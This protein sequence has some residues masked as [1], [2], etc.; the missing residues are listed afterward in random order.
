M[1]SQQTLEFSCCQAQAKKMAP[2]VVV[3]QIAG[4]KRCWGQGKETGK[5]GRMLPA[6]NALGEA[7]PFVLNLVFKVFKTSTNIQ[8]PLL[9]PVQNLPGDFLQP[10]GRIHCRA[11]HAEY[12]AIP[13]LA[14]SLT[15]AADH[16]TLGQ[17]TPHYLWVGRCSVVDVQAQGFLPAALTDQVCCIQSDVLV[18]DFIALEKTCGKQQH[19]THELMTCHLVGM[20][21]VTCAQP[22]SQRAKQV[23][24]ARLP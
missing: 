19:E 5:E 10:S 15:H 3:L 1:G 14:G 13:V 18:Q 17:L 20:D 7:I 22:E 2:R 21:L 16:S 4:W 24:R 8:L 23:I 6:A 12:Q 11:G 9:F